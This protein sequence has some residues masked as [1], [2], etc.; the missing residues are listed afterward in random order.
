LGDYAAAARGFETVLRLSPGNGEAREYL[1]EIEKGGAQSGARSIAPP[2]ALDQRTM[3]P[4]S[5]PRPRAKFPSP[6]SNSNWSQEIDILKRLGSVRWTAA[7][8][9]PKSVRSQ[10]SRVLEENPVSISVV[11]A[12]WNRGAVVNKAIE[13]VLGQTYSVKELIVVDD[14]SEDGTI[15][16]IRERFH[17][18]LACRRLVVIERPHQ[19]V[20][21]ARNAGLE[22]ASGE[23]IAYLD[24]DNFWHRDFTL[25]MGA[26]FAAAPHLGT[27]YCGENIHDLD[28]NEN[29]MLLDQYNRA[30]ILGRSRI[31]LNCF[32]HRR[33]IYLQRGGFDV[34]LTRL[35]DW[36]L[37]IRY[38]QYYSPAVIP[39]CLVEYFLDAKHLKNVTYTESWELNWKIVIKKHIRER[40]LYAV[41]PLRV[42]YVIWDWPALSQTFVMNEL[43]WLIN[44]S[45]DVRVYFKTIP[46]VAVALDFHIEAQQVDTYE[47]LAELLV[48]DQRNVLHTPFAYPAAALLTWPAAR[49]CKIPFTFMPAGV[50]ITHYENRKRNQVGEMS[51][52]PLCV[53]AIVA[54]SAHRRLL[55]ECGVPMAKMVME[56][57]AV[58]LPDFMSHDRV[59]QASSRIRLISIARFIE[60]KGMR[61]LI[62][63]AAQL[64]E[65]D[66][67]IYGYGPLEGELRAQSARLGARNVAF[68]GTLDTTAAL[69]AAYHDADLL[70]LAC[71]EA[72]NGDTDGLPT[73]LLEAMAAGVPVV[74]SRIGNIPDLIVD[75]V[76]GFLAAP[77]DV[78]S[79]VAAIKRVASLEPA[80]R[81]RLIDRARQRAVTFASQ[82][83][84]MRTLVDIWRGRP[85]DVVLVTYD[86][87]EY[88]DWE[89]TRDIIDSIYEHTTLPFNL[90]VV[91]NGSQEPFR[92]NLCERYSRCSNFHFVELNRNLFVGPATNIGM[93]AGTSEY[94]VYMCSKEAFV[95]QNGW[96][97]AIVAGMDANPR[98]GMGG[99]LISLPHYRNGREY[100]SYP[101]FAMW[102]SQDFARRNPERRFRHVQGGFLVIR[103][104]AYEAVGGFSEHVV[105]DGTDIEYS[106]YLE[107]RGYELLD[108][109]DVYSVTKKTWPGP[110]TLID[111]NTLA[112]HALTRESF[113]RFKR[114]IEREVVHCNCCGWQGATFAEPDRERCPEC[115]SR[116]FDRTVMRH[117][118]LSG[119]LQRR[120][121]LI[122]LGKSEALRGAVAELCSAITADAG[123]CPCVEAAVAAAIESAEG[124]V[125]VIDHDVVPFDGMVERLI[126][127]VTSGGRLIIGD[128]MAISAGATEAALH[129]NLATRGVAVDELRSASNSLGLDTRLVIA[130]GFPE[131]RELVPASQVTTASAALGRSA[132]QLLN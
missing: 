28:K 99:Y 80:E 121:N 72:S 22:Y 95:L 132:A 70:A 1:L 103:R 62:D 41:E 23:L 57:Q 113:G 83:R 96:D 18:A 114:L 91:D 68:P 87:P 59:R 34:K 52:D 17:D 78:A 38:T 74:T 13:S 88:S 65:V 130:V 82:D 119:V 60:K 86:T 97:R 117:L 129:V 77:G 109:A 42:G 125:L 16:S 105:H 127:F 108:I 48:R 51:A 47:Q 98:A 4:P 84:M 8:T 67:V 43:R 20:S 90:I 30:I 100:A 9:V 122:C 120:P 81:L 6:N 19:G 101:G 61:F 14:G 112:M 40:L 66:F 24:S 71:V 49:A 58:G 63:A 79:L 10:C 92:R 50:D 104:A 75:G 123:D 12:T 33:S 45:V 126:E 15:Q 116:P 26:V 55:A 102:R 21:P 106:Y 73:V 115:G 69:H 3:Q 54:G 5:P 11:M 124:T 107:S 27:A 29:S 85:L 25:Y 31:D 128:T 46:D 93:Q 76:H 53:G 32:M 94:I 111:E 2:L 89:T 35:V 56:R 131:T 39:I 7:E 118:S 44:N 64:P 110:K 36:E 37:I